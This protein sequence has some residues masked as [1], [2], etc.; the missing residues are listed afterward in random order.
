VMHRWLSW[1][2]VEDKLK[3][4]LLPFMHNVI[5]NNTPHFLCDNLVYAGFCHGHITRQ[6]ST[7]LLVVPSPETNLM[8]RTR[9]RFPIT[10]DLRFTRTIILTMDLANHREFLWS[11]SRNSS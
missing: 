5:W 1:L 3:C 4:C 8:M 2:S 7:G 11:V 9:P 10:M 6:V